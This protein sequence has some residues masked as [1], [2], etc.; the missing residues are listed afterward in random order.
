MR[1]GGE[2]VGKGGRGWKGEWLGWVKERRSVERMPRHAPSMRPRSI[3]PHAR[4]C[5]HAGTTCVALHPLTPHSRLKCPSP[6]YVGVQVPRPPPHALLVGAAVH[7]PR[8]L[9]P[10]VAVLRHQLRQQGVLLRRPLVLLDVRIH[11]VAPTLRA[12]LPGPAGTICSKPWRR[13]R[14]RERLSTRASDDTSKIH[15]LYSQNLP[16]GDELRHHGPLVAVQLL[17]RCELL[18]LVRIPGPGLRGITCE[19]M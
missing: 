9:R 12:L 14:P 1:E 13:S 10:P 7:V 8:N 18:V 16:P 17:I 11:L 6:G 2:L 4:P 3:A 15:A 19:R 5:T